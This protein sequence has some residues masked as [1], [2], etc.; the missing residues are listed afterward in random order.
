MKK[1]FNAKKINFLILVALVFSACNQTK[2]APVGKYA[3]V[4]PPDGH[5]MVLNTTTGEVSF[6]I[7]KDGFRLRKINMVTGGKTEI[8]LPNY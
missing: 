6:I 4:Y 8:P 2:E 7:N 3:V 5:F 1:K